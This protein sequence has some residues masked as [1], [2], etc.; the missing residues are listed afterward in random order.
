MRKYIRLNLVQT[1]S[2]VILCVASTICLAA[3]ESGTDTTVE[4]TYITPDQLTRDDWSMIS[5]H[6]DNY[7]N[8]LSTTSIEQLQSQADP[9]NVVDYA[10]K[11]CAVELETLDKKMIE[12]NYD[13]SFRFGYLHRISNNGANNT[14]RM[15]MMTMANQPSQSEQKSDIQDK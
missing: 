7:N 3:D 6:T 14:L 13:P 5:E 15:V 1:C 2:Y 9:R 8:C 11:H 10:M 4:N 12:R